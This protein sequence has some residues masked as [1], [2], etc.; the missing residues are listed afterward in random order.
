MEDPEIGSITHKLKFGDNSLGWDGNAGLA[1]YLGPYINDAGVEV[2]TCWTV[3][4][5]GQGEP[6][7][8]M[9]CDSRYHN[10][11]A[12]VREHNDRLRR[13]LQIQH[14]AKEA[15]VRDQIWTELSRKSRTRHYLK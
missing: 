8:V 9:R 10:V 12:E 4:M 3:W 14:A 5:F 11:A 1:I 2:G 13:E 7:I 6:Y 15:E